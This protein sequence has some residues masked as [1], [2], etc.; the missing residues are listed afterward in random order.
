[1]HPAQAF[2]NSTSQLLARDRRAA[3][4]AEVRYIVERKGGLSG[5][6]SGTSPATGPTPEYSSRRSRVAGLA[7]ELKVGKKM[8]LADCFAAAL[9]LVKRRL[10]SVEAT[11]YRLSHEPTSLTASSAAN[12]GQLSPA[13][14]SNCIAVPHCRRGSDSVSLWKN[15]SRECARRSRA[16]CCRRADSRRRT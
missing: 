9:D 4:V 12:P 8:S 16:I 10:K 3:E 14:T 11:Q 15:L 2:L 7:G 6:A 13:E 1:M 5:M